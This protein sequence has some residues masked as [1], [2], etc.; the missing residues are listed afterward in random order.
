M[1]RVY[2]I[3]TDRIISQ[4]EK[5]T[6][7]WQRPWSKEGAW[8]KNLVSGKEYRGVNV[9][10]LS[11]GG[12]T[13]PYWLTFKQAQDLGG[14]VNKGEHGSPV[15]F[16][17]VNEREKESPEGETK[18]EKSMILRYYTVF[19]LSQ[20]VL[21]EKHIPLATKTELTFQP[22]EVCENVVAKMPQKPIIRHGEQRAWYKPHADLVNMPKYGTFTIPEA[23]YSTLFHEL[24]HSTGHF[25]RLNRSGI[26]ELTHFGS[27][28]YSKEELVAEMGAAFLCG[29]TGIENHTIDNSASYIAGWLKKLRGDSKLVILAAADAQ[30]AADFVLGVKLT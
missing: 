15:I 8:P 28:N 24:T 20:M 25:S 26:T 16:W 5:G 22:I 30:K 27:T 23:Y 10:L 21:P 4:L 19:N 9:F 11:A 2:Q 17:K 13:S 1:S 29:H 7:P 3:I 14:S 18:T 6:V 12:Y